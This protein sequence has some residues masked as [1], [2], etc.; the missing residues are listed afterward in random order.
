MDTESTLLAGL[1]LGKSIEIPMAIAIGITKAPTM[2]PNIMIV[3][4]TTATSNSQK[5]ISGDR[6]NDGESSAC[7]SPYGPF[8]ELIQ[9]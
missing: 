7:W 2:I 6:P 3:M 4:K 8:H 5:K 9:G 1:Q